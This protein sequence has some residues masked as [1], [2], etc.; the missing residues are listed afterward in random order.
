MLVPLHV[1]TLFVGRYISLYDLRKTLHKQRPEGLP[2]VEVL[3]GH[4]DLS[5]RFDILIYYLPRKGCHESSM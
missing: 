5:F 4:R 3:Q 1:D 2:T